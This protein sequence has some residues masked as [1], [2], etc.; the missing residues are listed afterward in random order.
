MNQ[1]DFVDWNIVI[2]FLVVNFCRSYLNRSDDG[3]SFEDTFGFGDETVRLSVGIENIEDLIDDLEQ[4]F[5][6]AF[7]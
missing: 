3:T 6:K 4:A 2:S 1:S 5:G 7:Q